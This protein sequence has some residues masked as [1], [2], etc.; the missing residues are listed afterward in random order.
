[1]DFQDEIG[2]TI[3]R[4][5]EMRDSKFNFGVEFPGL[6]EL[7][8]RHRKPEQ[9]ARDERTQ[10]AMDPELTRLSSIYR[11][12][13]VRCVDP[14]Y[15][16]M[17]IYHISGEVPAGLIVGDAW[18]LD[19]VRC[20]L[21]ERESRTADGRRKIHYSV[22]PIRKVEDIKRRCLFYD[23]PVCVVSEYYCGRNF[24][25]ETV[26]CP[27]HGHKRYRIESSG[28]IID[29]HMA[30]ATGIPEPFWGQFDVISS[31]RYYQEQQRL[32]GKGL[33]IKR[34]RAAINGFDVAP[35]S[36]LQHIGRLKA[37]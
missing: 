33:D 17:R 24:R 6:D 28:E 12:H 14:D 11:A 20:Q 26:L 19:V 22:K 37:A 18:E 3:Q 35:E 16:S 25:R 2:K 29:V 1:M 27:I 21:N 34:V 31:Q 13:S 36:L 32:L 4:C 7:L 23:N 10:N 5:V 15:G 8:Y 9:K 30:V